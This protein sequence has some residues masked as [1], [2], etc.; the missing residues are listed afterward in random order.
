[1]PQQSPSEHDCA[2]LI[3]DEIRLKW[4]S[5][6]AQTCAIFWAIS[7]DKFDQNLAQMKLELSNEPRIGLHLEWDLGITEMAGSTLSGGLLW[8]IFRLS[9]FSTVLIQPVICLSR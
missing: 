3:N 7:H 2:L 5:N 6:P 9:A 1:M 8:T 4:V